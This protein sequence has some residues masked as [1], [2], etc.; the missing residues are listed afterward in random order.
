MGPEGELEEDIGL[1]AESFEE[2]DQLD[3]EAPD[4]DV[5]EQRRSV[6]PDAGDA[7]TG[8]DE[9]VEADEADIADQQRAVPYLADE[10]DY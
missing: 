3:T 4:W 1:S 6:R 7:A 5:A 8:P 9:I 2:G 10:E